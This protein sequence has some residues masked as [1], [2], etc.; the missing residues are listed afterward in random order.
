MVL[1]D[2]WQFND[3]YAGNLFSFAQRVVLNTFAEC[4]TAVGVL[5]YGRF[6]IS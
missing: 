5:C 3:S 1:E 6:P 2:A 4:W